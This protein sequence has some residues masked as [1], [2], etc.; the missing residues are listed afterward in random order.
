MSDLDA[1]MGQIPINQLAQTLQTDPAEVQ[2]AVR[3]LL[4]ALVGGMQAN[5][6]DPAGARS[7]A[8]ALSDHAQSDVPPVDAIDTDDGQKIVRNIFGGSTDD[9]IS[10][11]GAQGGGSDLIGKLLPML[12]PI[13]M[14]L[15]AKQLAGGG[16]LGGIFGGGSSRSGGGAGGSASVDGTIGS[17][18]APG[19]ASTPGG[20][21]GGLTDMLGS[22][23]GGGSGSG[24][25]G[26]GGLNDILGG[27]LGGM[28]GGG[29][30]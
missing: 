19:S 3:S 29:K 17:G 26:S 27:V 18:M 21:L 1:L 9:V 22:I 20:G 30:R 10:T 2:Q 25:G 28:L 11:L 4:P 24:S 12:A 8:G 14:S 6:E 16:G 13:V 7:L 23:L 15:I 5:A